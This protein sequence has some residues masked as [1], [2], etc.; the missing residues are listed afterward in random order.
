MFQNYDTAE[1]LV[2]LSQLWEKMKWSNGEGIKR[3][4]VGSLVR[5]VNLLLLPL[6]S[7]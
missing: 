2:V 3:M 7:G 5:V 1:L 4:P 6:N